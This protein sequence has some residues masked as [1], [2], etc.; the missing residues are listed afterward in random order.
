MIGTLASYQIPKRDT[1]TQK[2]QVYFTPNFL[3]KD[4]GK[5]NIL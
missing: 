2:K 5:E 3:N 4:L 1:I